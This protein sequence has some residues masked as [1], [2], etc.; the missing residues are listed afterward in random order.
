MTQSP[1][2]QPDL[3]KISR[4]CIA[5]KIRLLNRV[6][7]KIYNDALSPLQIKVGQMNVLVIEAREEPVS[8]VDLG[9]VLQMDKSTLSRTVDRLRKQG[10]LEVSSG[11][12]RSQNLTVSAKGRRILQKALPLWRQAQ[13]RARKALSEA[14]VEALAQTADH[15]WAHIGKA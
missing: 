1:K 5:A 12:G 13:R 8:A 9:P 10:W 4:Q 7:T 15:L 2:T 11:G 6:I 3:D 14:G